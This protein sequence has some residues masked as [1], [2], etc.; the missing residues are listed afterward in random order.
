[1]IFT[2]QLLITKLKATGV[3]LSMSI[4]VFIFLAY[5]IYYNWYPQPYFEIDGGWQGIRL[6]GA[7]DLVLGPLITFLIFN[8]SK[9]RRE[10]IFDLI[11]IVTIQI[12]A[13]VYGVYA[14]YS[15]RPVAIVLIDEFVVPAIVENYGGK[16]ESTDQ[17]EQYSVESP[18]IIFAD[19][20][21]TQE[22]VA[23]INRIKIEQG[24]M[25]HAQMRL[26]RPKPE[27]ATA[28]KQRQT[29]FYDRLD[30]FGARNQFNYWLQQ[31]QK[32]ETD[33]LIARFSGRYGVVWL[34][35]DLEGNYLSYF[36]EFG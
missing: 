9:P 12:G 3:H 6:V 4:V 25:D 36:D 24:I 15:Q 8:L 14:T 31:N 22:A 28:L 2:R 26:Y 1:M 30:H 16:L 13:L 32:T 23:E 20:P 34:V 11:I 35:F 19:M 5:Q 27:L 10:I 21:K 18:P 7:V 29:M 33:V 17:L